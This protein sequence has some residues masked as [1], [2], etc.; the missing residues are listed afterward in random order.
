MN[1]EKVHENIIDEHDALW[2]A[3]S[4]LEDTVTEQRKEIDRLNSGK[5]SQVNQENQIDARTR[6][7]KIS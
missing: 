2:E 6:V 7:L 3:I 4:S 5:L 1:H